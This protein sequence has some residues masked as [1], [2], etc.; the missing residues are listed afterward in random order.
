M[1]LEKFNRRITPLREGLLHKARAMTGNDDTAEDLVQEV[2]LR[3]W[4]MRDKL[5][6]HTS[7]PALAATML[8]HLHI[9][10]QRHLR[11]EQGREAPEPT[12]K[13]ADHDTELSDTAAIIRSIIDHLPPLQAQVFRLKE[14]EGYEAEEIIAITGC[15]PANLRQCLSRARKR[16]KEEYLRITM[17]RR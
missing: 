13:A 11:L 10:H 8:H 16:I 6:H 2:M 9:D 17:P 5:D 3:L 1:E 7:P 4:T 12:A 15:S 14:V